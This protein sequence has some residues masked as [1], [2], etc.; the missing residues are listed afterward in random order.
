M[1]LLGGKNYNILGMKA[2]TLLRN[3]ND[4]RRLLWLLVNQDCV[5]F[6]VFINDLRFNSQDDHFSIFVYSDDETSKII[7]KIYKLA[8]ERLYLL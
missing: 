2:R 7:D 6:F 4:I 1:S 8:K 3:V 5:S